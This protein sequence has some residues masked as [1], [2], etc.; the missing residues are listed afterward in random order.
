MGSYPTE[1][2]L[3][4][5][6]PSRRL[7][8]ANRIRPKS[9]VIIAARSQKLFFPTR[10]GAT[11]EPLRPVHSG[12]VSTRGQRADSG[13]STV[14]GLRMHFSQFDQSLTVMLFSTAVQ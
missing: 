6:R 11:G 14:G 7:V 13:D 1:T 2:I 4:Q 9:T 8:S 10:N 3:I 12:C 5:T